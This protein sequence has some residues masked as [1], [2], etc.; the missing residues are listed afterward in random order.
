MFTLYRNPMDNSTVIVHEMLEEDFLMFFEYLGVYME[1]IMSSE[2][3]IE[4]E[5]KQILVDL[6]E[7]LCL[8]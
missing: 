5:Q 4:L 3:P 8:N 1:S 2:N 7:D 6:C